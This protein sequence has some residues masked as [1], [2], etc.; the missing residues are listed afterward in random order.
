MKV[1]HSTTG[2][3]RERPHYEL[4]DIEMICV[5]ELRSAGL[6]P[7]SPNPIRIDRLIEKRFHITHRYDDLPAGVL[8]YTKFGPNGVES[9]VVAR[10]LSEEGSKVGERRITT[11]LAHETGHVLLHAYLFALGSKPRSLF[12]DADQDVPELLCRDIPA[13]SSGKRTYDGRWWEYQ[14]NRA[15]GGLLL[16]RELVRVALGQYLVL[17]GTL[18]RQT[19]AQVE[20]EAAAASLSEI[21]DVNPIVARIR[22]NELYPETEQLSL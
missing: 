3:F 1:L 9:I 19:I 17:A 13:V 5:D 6:Y 20:R 21:F 12:D 10:V 7:T 8:G 14:A 15:I 22:I 2:P 4:H 16:P 11:T 18:G